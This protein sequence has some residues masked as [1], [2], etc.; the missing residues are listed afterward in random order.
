MSRIAVGVFHV[1]VMS[2]SVTVSQS[3]HPYRILQYFNLITDP[4]N[5]TPCRMVEPNQYTEAKMR[6]TY[7]WMLFD[8]LGI[9]VKI[10]A[11][12]VDRSAPPRPVAPPFYA[13]PEVLFLQVILNKRGSSM[14]SAEQYWVSGSRIGAGGLF[15]ELLFD[16]TVLPNYM[17]H[18][19]IISIRNLGLWS[20]TGFAPDITEKFWD[21]TQKLFTQRGVEDAPGLVRLMRHMLVLNPAKPPVH[22]SFSMIRTSLAQT[23]QGTSLATFIPL[24]GFPP[25]FPTAK[26][27]IFRQIAPISRPWIE[28]PTTVDTAY[29]EEWLQ[30]DQRTIA[31]MFCVEKRPAIGNNPLLCVT[32]RVLWGWN[33]NRPAKL[34]PSNLIISYQTVPGYPLRQIISSP[35]SDL[36]YGI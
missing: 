11:Y 20:I 10:T 7:H 12:V 3:F 26:R 27:R 1:S 16:D 35:T 14:G 4:T 5:F 15:P 30:L 31:W 28:F 18:G 13:A 23:A 36:K 33:P 19:A 17:T 6:V 21:G 22:K 24:C 8:P 2:T 9:Y 25:A 32:G 29:V 34:V